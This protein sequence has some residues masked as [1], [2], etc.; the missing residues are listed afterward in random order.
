[1]KLLLELSLKLV[2]IKKTMKLIINFI[3]EH[4]NLSDLVKCEPGI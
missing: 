4:T 1:M 3:D 2:E